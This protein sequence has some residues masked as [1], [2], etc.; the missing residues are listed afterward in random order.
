MIY[1]GD[2]C[3]EEAEAIKEQITEY[4]RWYLGDHSSSS[5]S[6]LFLEQIIEYNLGSTCLP[7]SEQRFLPLQTGP[8]RYFAADLQKNR[9]WTHCRKILRLAGIFAIAVVLRR[10]AIRTSGVKTRRKEAA[11]G[12]TGTASAPRGSFRTRWLR[13]GLE[14]G[15]LHGSARTVAEAARSGGGAGRR[16][17][18]GAGRRRRG[19]PAGQGPT[20]F[21]SSPAA[22][23]GLIWTA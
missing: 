23:V 8:L 22:A 10:A 18:G 20:P 13:P 9:E 7:S 15:N 21:Q 3:N 1:L 16:R 19:G 6:S 17:R 11:G 4:N 14:L 12:L 5:S 2:H